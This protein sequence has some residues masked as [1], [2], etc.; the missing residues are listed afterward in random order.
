MTKAPYDFSFVERL[1]EALAY[2][3]SLT[4]TTATG[5]SGPM[6]DKLVEGILSTLNLLY[7]VISMEEIYDIQES[8]ER[9]LMEIHM[10]RITDILT[11][12]F[13][14]PFISTFSNTA[15]FFAK[16]LF[17]LR[18]S[19]RPIAFFSMEPIF[20][21]YIE[22]ARRL[23][24]FLHGYEDI[25]SYPEASSMLKWDALQ[26]MLLDTGQLQ[27]SLSADYVEA[28]GI[29]MKLWHKFGLN[30]SYLSPASDKV[31]DIVK[32]TQELCT[33]MFY[34]YLLAFLY[35]C[36]NFYNEESSHMEQLVRNLNEAY[37]KVDTETRAKQYI[38][39]VQIRI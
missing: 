39:Q 14:Y 27:L 2:M 37:S 1:Y 36:S 7:V 30:L 8:N 16:V 19:S 24:L 9:G 34:A 21:R 31:R 35:Q 10:G 22:A 15:S 28:G 18:R 33:E 3:L 38:S 20:Y 12:Q 5:Y 4:D 17:A 32:Y 26:G 6:L 25:I 23:T 29:M 11:S 13:F